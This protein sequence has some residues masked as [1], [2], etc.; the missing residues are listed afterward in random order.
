LIAYLLIVIVVVV[1]WSTCRQPCS[2]PYRLPINYW[3]CRVDL[4][5]LL[6]TIGVAVDLF[7]VRVT[8][9]VIV[10]VGGMPCITVPL[11]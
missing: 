2:V 1:Y 4:V 9:I 10:I 3:Y 7:V 5:D 11:R 6:I 8:G